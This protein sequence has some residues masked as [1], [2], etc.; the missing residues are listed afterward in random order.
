M[1]T[2]SMGNI[3]MRW[4]AITHIYI[5][6]FIF[7]TKVRNLYLSRKCLMIIIQ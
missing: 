3:R 2:W 7:I 5:L 4:G 1:Y 6:H